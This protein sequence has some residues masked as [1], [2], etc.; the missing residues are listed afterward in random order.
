MEIEK[1]IIDIVE[2]GNRL[3]FKSTYSPIVCGN[4]GYYLRFEFSENWKK[5]LHKTAILILD[6]KKFAIDFEENIVEV[7][8]LPNCKWLYVALTSSVGEEVAMSTTS[9]KIRLEPSLVAEDMS[10]FNPVSGYLPKMIGLLNRYE[11]GEI[12]IETA[13]HAN[14]ATTAETATHAIS[15]ST[16]TTAETASNANYATT[17]GSSAT[18]V[19]LINDQT[20]SG[21]KNF[22]GS[23]KIN[24]KEVV[25]TETFNEQIN[26]LNSD[27]SD[28]NDNLDKV[29][30]FEIV[31]DSLS[32]N[33]NL[34]WGY[35]AGIGKDVTVTGRDFSKYKFLILFSGTSSKLYQCNFLISLEYNTNNYFGLACAED[36]SNNVNYQC[37]INSSKTSISNTSG[38]G[39][40]VIYKI[41]GAV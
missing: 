9:I 30:Y 34:N 33:S 19:D 32:S 7:P 16:A 2:D 39:D 14:T 20:I 36:G 40:A 41:L 24:G 38:Y 26:N 15:A 11:Q 22:V 21:E 12:Y 5:C 31:Y 23:L 1:Y 17:A 35:T 29:T 27:I 18:Q 25:N 4:T 10:E 37:K 3:D 8:P 28:I 13:N 6:N